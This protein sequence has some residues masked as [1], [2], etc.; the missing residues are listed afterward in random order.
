MDHTL[1]IPFNTKRA[2]NSLTLTY[3]SFFKKNKQRIVEFRSFLAI[4]RI[5]QIHGVKGDPLIKTTSRAVINTTKT[6]G[7]QHWLW[8]FW[9]T[10]TRKSCSFQK[11]SPLPK[12]PFWKFRN[13]IV[14]VCLIPSGPRNQG[15]SGRHFDK[16]PSL[17]LTNRHGKS[18]ILMV[19]TRKHGDFHGDFVSFR[20]G[21]HENLLSAP[22]KVYLSFF[23]WKKPWHWGGEWAP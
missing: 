3:L 14:H 6:D 8:L 16:L 2:R 13:F 7:T 22:R 10:R 19:F 15:T 1:L 9:P 4:F 5:T 17:K 11:E 18:S 20:E 23:S 21:M 12:F